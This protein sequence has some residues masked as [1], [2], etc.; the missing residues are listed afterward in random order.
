MS[1]I[2]LDTETTGLNKET[3]RIVEIGI[4]DW[5]DGSKLLL[6]RLNPGVPIPSV[7][8]A[9]HGIG[10]DDVAD[11]PGFDAIAGDLKAIIERAEAVIG[12]HIFY[13]YDMVTAEFNRLS[14]TVQWPPLVCAKRVWDVYEPREE[15]HLHNAY[16]RFVDRRGFDNAHTALADINATRDVLMAQIDTFGL[17]DVP[18]HQMDPERRFWWGPSPHILLTH[19]GELRVNFGKWKG[20][21]IHEVDAGFWRWLTTKDFPDHITLLALEMVALDR[22]PVEERMKKIFV[23]ALDYKARKFNAG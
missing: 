2:V 6:Q 8:T 14:M 17:H 19:T 9:I 1:A 10:D 23:W 15:R 12:Y 4:I 16:R 7:V 13:D 22:L 11:C 18:W 3:D 21:Q 5:K 20:K